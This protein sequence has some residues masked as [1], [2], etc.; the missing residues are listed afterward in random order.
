MTD[1]EWNM[2][3]DDLKHRA[4]YQQIHHICDSKAGWIYL[5]DYTGKRYKFT[6][7]EPKAKFRLLF[8][9]VLYINTNRIVR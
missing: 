2:L 5:T 8:D 1:Y 4:T 3:I 9:H 6:K 7:D